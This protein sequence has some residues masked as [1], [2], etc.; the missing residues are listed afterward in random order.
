MTSNKFCKFL[1]NGWSIFQN[2]QGIIVKPCCWYK[3]DILLNGNNS[4]DHLH[5]ID[6]WTPQCGVCKQQEDSGISSF[7]QASFD[8]IP[9]TIPGKPVAIDIS[10]DFNCNAACITCGPDVSTLWQKEFKKSQ[11]IYSIV[12]NSINTVL[13]DLDLSHLRRIKFFGGEPLFTN[14][15]LQVLKKIPDPSQVEI[16]YTTNG[17]IYPTAE[18]FNTWSQ[19]KLVFFEVSIDGIGEQ[20]NYIRWPLKW[21]KVENNLLRLVKEAPVNVMFRVNHTLNLFNVF[22]YNRLTD[23]VKNTF[24]TNRLGDPTEINVHPCWGIWDLEKTPRSLRDLINKT[25]PAGI[26]NRLLLNTKLNSNLSDIDNF[27]NTWEHRRQNSWKEVFPD[28]VEYFKELC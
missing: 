20:F 25:E 9:D 16:W 3:E 18:V 22:Y 28:I 17:S 14:T 8:I 13:A 1:T 2:Q 5:Q 27:I 7:R 26:V 19:F 23:W 10:L 24:S 4:L 12:P 21:D 11:R 6:N 15:H